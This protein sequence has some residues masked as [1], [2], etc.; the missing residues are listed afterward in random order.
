MQCQINII[1]KTIQILRTLI[2]VIYYTLIS[3]F[4]F[5]TIFLLLI[6]FFPE[7]LPAIFKSYS[8]LF[9]SMF[10]WKIYLDPLITVIN[11]VLLIVAMFFIKKGISFFLKSDFYNEK[12][13]SNLK[14]AGNIFIF[15]GI[16]TILIKF[17]TVLYMQNIIQIRTP[18]LFKTYSLI[19]ATIDLKSI[20]SIIIGLFFLLFS[21][22]F[23]NASILK[24]ENDLTI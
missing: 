1:M 21:Q 9:Y 10:S 4:I 23:K 3:V 24:Q 16:S 2:N 12:V 20:I 6:F 14:K 7:Y 18:F 5:G 17:Y 8:T 15:I 22:I 13:I 11:Y 19:S